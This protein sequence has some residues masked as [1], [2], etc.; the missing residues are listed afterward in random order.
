M[1]SFPGSPE[2]GPGRVVELEHVC[3]MTTLFPGY[4]GG[5]LG[6]AGYDGPRPVHCV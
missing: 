2:G 5:D 1:G 6:T 4:P 3:R